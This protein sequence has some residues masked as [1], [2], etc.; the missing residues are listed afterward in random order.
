MLYFFSDTPYFLEYLNICF[1]IIIINYIQKFSLYFTFSRQKL[2]NFQGEFFEDY[3][4]YSPKHPNIAKNLKIFVQK[5][6]Y[7]I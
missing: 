3:I 6:S 7:T 2:F 4:R 5:W 1:F